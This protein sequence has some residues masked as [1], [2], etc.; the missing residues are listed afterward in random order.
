[1]TLLRQENPR[2]STHLQNPSSGG[3]HATDCRIDATHEKTNQAT[4]QTGFLRHEPNGR[5]RSKKAS[6]RALTSALL[7]KSSAKKAAQLD[8]TNTC[9]PTSFAERIEDC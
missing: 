2:T 6:R 9:A 3:L 5:D 1:M 4:E 7:K 8:E